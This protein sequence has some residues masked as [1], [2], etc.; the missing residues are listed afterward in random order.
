MGGSPGPRAGRYAG[1]DRRFVRVDVARLPAALL[2]RLG[3]SAAPTSLAVPTV[4]LYR[5]GAELARRPTLDPVTGGVC[6][7]SVADLTAFVAAFKAFLPSPGA[8]A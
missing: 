7:S 3:L 6:H 2:A 4:A 1:P 8:P 5:G